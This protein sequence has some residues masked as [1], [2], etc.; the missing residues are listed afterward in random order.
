MQSTHVEIFINAPIERV[1]DAVTDHE[2]FLTEPG[3]SSCR[4]TRPG[5][6]EKNGLG[7]LRE[8]RAGAFRFVEEIT[9]FE[10]PTRMDYLIRESSGP[11]HHEVSRFD[12]A[13]LGSGT[14][15][16][17]TGR[18]EIPVF[19]VGPLLTRFSRAVLARSIHRLL[20]QARAR[21][22]PSNS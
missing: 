3:A 1:F 15:V 16:T 8:I 9:V 4:V 19:L 7:C 12:F 17:W 13:P 21:L 22:E 11:V 20:V 10:R 18:F 14:K 2:Q 6:P 5:Q